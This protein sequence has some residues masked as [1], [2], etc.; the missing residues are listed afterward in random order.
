MIDLEKRLGPWTRRVWGLVFN[1]F[2][3]A[4]AIYGGMSVLRGDSAGFALWT[5]V[6]ITVLCVLVLARPDR[7]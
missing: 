2:G 6:A 7:S 4:L 5:G 3:N 1:F